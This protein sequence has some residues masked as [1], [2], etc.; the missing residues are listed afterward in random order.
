MRSPAGAGLRGSG[1][2]GTRTRDLRRDRPPRPPRRP[3]T[4]DDE[5][6]RIPHPAWDC[7]RS[8]HAAEPNAPG[9]HAARCC[10]ELVSEGLAP[11]ARRRAHGA[12][13]SQAAPSRRL[14]KRRPEWEFGAAGVDAPMLCLCTTLGLDGLTAR[15]L[16]VRGGCLECES[17]APACTRKQ[18]RSK[19]GRSC[20]WS[21]EAFLSV[22]GSARSVDIKRRQG[23]R[24]CHRT[25]Q[26]ADRR[27][28]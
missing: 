7:G 14:R 8:G 2:D 13:T 25:G 20:C 26:L 5:P 27:S 15:L 3:A 22:P 21:C 6:R 10:V 11:A 17:S 9:A 12:A 1:S 18:S 23:L 24:G 28:I 19:V 16:V 4:T